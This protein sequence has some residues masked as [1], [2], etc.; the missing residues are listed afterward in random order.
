MVQLSKSNA[1]Y[2]NIQQGVGET[3]VDLSSTLPLSFHHLNNHADDRYSYC[4]ALLLFDFTNIC[5][6]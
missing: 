4:C 5:H 6:L 2:V 3:Q 1:F